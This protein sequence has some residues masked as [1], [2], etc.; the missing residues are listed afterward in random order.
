VPL[1]GQVTCTIVNTDD[2]PSLKLVKDVHNNDGGLNT[3]ADWKLSADAAAPDTGRNFDSQ[4]ATPTFHDVFGGIE[5]TLSENPNAGTGYSSSGIWSCDGGTFTSPDK[6]T[7]PLGG[8]VTCTI[9][10]TDDTPSLKL[11]KDV[12]NND[13]GSA[14]PKDFTLSATAQTGSASRDFS[15]ATN[16]PVFHDV[17]GSTVY[18]LAES[19]PAGYAAG[20]WSCDGGTQSGATISVPLGGTVTCEITNDDQA[21][22]L[23]VIKHVINDNGGSAVAADFTLDSGGTN[24]TPDNFAG[25]EAPGTEVTLDAGSYGVT[26]SGPA[27]YSASYS[28]DCAGSIANGVTK[29]CTVTNNDQA[30]K[31]IVIK[32]VINDN[33]GTATASAFTMSVTGIAANPASFPGA[34]SPGTNVAL[35]AGS[36]NVTESGP[37]GYTASSTPSCTGSIAVGQ[38]KT[39]TFT[40]DD[41]QPKLTVI[42]HVINDDGGPKNASDFT[43]NV[44]GNSPS[45]ASFPGAESPGT[46]VAL[47]AGSY[48]V[49]EAAMAGY[50]KSLGAGC[51]GS[52]AIG[53]TKS[54]T[55]TNDDGNEAPVITSFTGTGSLFGPLVFAPSTFSGTFFDSA[56]ADNPWAVSWSW[57][58]TADPSANQTVG[59]NGTQNHNFGPQTHTYTSAGCNHT[60]TVT[61]TDKDGAT[62]TPATVTVGVGTGGFLPP[63]TNQPVT[64]KLKNG[65]V[66]PVKI[67]ITDC[68]GAGVNNLTP[69]IR[70]VAGDQTTV[71]DD[72]SVAI[73]PP[74]VSAAD[75]N[76]Q[77][78]S[79]GSDGSYIYNMNVSIPLNTDYTVV[80]YPYWT[81]G[82]PSGP[83]LRH[84]IQ[85]T[86]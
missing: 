78:R 21:G 53:Q 23:I 28:A 44:T 73:T 50:A 22:K 12:H 48:S 19:G 67:Q 25:E 36:Y 6:I 75:T 10:N 2:T 46:N 58:G 64:N 79:T 66:L 84:V 49:D 20:A 30:G 85:A 47:N 63:M 1:G 32:H 29:T 37:T 55:I 24:D 34:E 38:T 74:S 83:T 80:I 60:A 62:S 70:L 26:E 82:T 77:M 7:V 5:Y 59:P 17:F 52:I 45:P 13:G 15:S 18:D 76:G 43:M 81:S 40:N 16:T 33:G 41:I 27:G 54:C 86:K 69:A 72:S 14:E 35:N 11:V 9:V 65:Q 71:Y 4:T 57:D 31:L 68:N 56:I 51:S 3:A 8:Q 42:K 39:C 61:I